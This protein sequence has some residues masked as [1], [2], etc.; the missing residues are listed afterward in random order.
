MR[1]KWEAF[2]SRESCTIATTSAAFFWSSN[3]S[4]IRKATATSRSR[5]SGSTL[6][7]FN[8]RPSNDPPL[9]SMPNATAEEIN[10]N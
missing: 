10:N 4:E 2:P 3:K 8:S 7:D 6:P 1:G 9:R 5:S